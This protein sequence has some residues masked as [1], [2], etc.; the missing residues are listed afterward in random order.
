MMVW[1]RI[2]LIWIFSFSGFGGVCQ[3]NEKFE[4][5]QSDQSST[6]VYEKLPVKLYKGNV[7][8]IKGEIYL[9][10]DSLYYFP[11]NNVNGYG[12]VRVIKSGKKSYTLTGDQLEFDWKKNQVL[13]RGNVFIRYKN[14]EKR[15]KQ[16]RFKLR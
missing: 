16:I 15:R 11:T 3:S 6:A 9:Y 10:C 5:V 12:N 7:E 4:F 2:I 13:I 1:E 8:F 14:K